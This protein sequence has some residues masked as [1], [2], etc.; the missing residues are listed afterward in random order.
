M[1]IGVRIPHTGRRATPEFV[2]AWCSTADAAG[3]D[4]L[5]GV[6]HVVMPQRVESR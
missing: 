2:R 1:E 3:F 5:W 6:D 4:S